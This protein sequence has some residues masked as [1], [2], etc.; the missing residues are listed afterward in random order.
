LRKGSLSP[1][2]DLGVNAEAKPACGGG[3]RLKPPIQRKKVS[4]TFFRNL[5]KM[6]RF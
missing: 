5:R 3:R 2:A 4:G 6:G 1:A